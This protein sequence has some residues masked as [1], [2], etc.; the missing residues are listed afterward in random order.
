[1]GRTISV[2]TAIFDGYDLSV[3]AE[4]VAAAGASHIEL[5]FTAGYVEGYAD[6][7][8]TEAK[9]RELADFLS[10]FGLASFSVASHMDLGTPEAVETFRRRLAFGKA[11]GATVVISNTTTTPQLDPFLRNIEQ[12][13]GVAESLGV[14]IGLENPGHGDDDILPTGQAAAEL[15]ARI[16]SAAVR[17]NYDVGNVFTYSHEALDPKDDIAAVLPATVNLHLK[18]IASSDWGWRFAPIG[19]GAI[20]YDTILA[21]L[22]GRG[23][24]L[25]LALE[26][27][28]RLGRPN[29][30]PPRR[31]DRPV[32][33][34]VIRSALR[35]SLDYVRRALGA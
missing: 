23:D 18:D 27:P 25:P 2:N 34:D 29:R 13:A 21:G 1:M 15:A 5:A 24:D 31:G 12:L 20:D 8:F 9:G 35:D 11:L 33:L 6:D 22:A 19:Q 3:A 26:I 32:E 7:F 4:E 16:G 10:G 30:A 17:V 28:L 14:V